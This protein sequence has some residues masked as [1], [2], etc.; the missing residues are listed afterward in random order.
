MEEV[1]VQE[2]L[3][4]DWCTRKV[5]FKSFSFPQVASTFLAHDVKKEYLFV[6]KLI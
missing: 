6:K 4:G 2:K 5:I 3:K 1:T